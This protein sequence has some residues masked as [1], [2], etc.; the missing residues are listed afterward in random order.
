MA[1]DK[2]SYLHGETIFEPFR[3]EVSLAIPAFNKRNIVE[4]HFALQTRLDSP[5]K[6]VATIS[7]NGAEDIHVYF[8]GVDVTSYYVKVL[9]SLLDKLDQKELA[10]AYAAAMDA[11]IDYADA[12]GAAYDGLIPT[13]KKD[14]AKLAA[15]KPLSSLVAKIGNRNHGHHGH[16]HL[17]NF[18]YGQIPCPEVT[19]TGVVNLYNADHPKTMINPA[20]I[21]RVTFSCG[22]SPTLDFAAWKKQAISPGGAALITVALQLHD[23]LED[24][25]IELQK[26]LQQL[27]DDITSALD[28][29]QDAL[30]PNGAIRRTIAQTG[31]TAD[32][33]L[34]AVKAARSDI[35]STDA[36]IGTQTQT[37]SQIKTQ[38]DAL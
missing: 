31:A 18:L 11:F 27:Q 26:Q 4:G 23:T 22:P 10:T 17:C 35:Q 2:V 30:S 3:S 5:P 12:M 32:Q 6:H 9:G 19:M 14:A 36:Q 8:D 21:Q 38:V 15:T 16:L 13:L 29:M 25:V 7:P 33:A 37:L 24:V 34:V 20:L 28:N 1:H